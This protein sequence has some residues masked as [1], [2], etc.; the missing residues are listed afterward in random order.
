MWQRFTPDSRAAILR[1]Q[2]IATGLK[3]A[4]IS[5][6]HLFLAVLEA[7]T[8]DSPLGVLLLSAGLKRE[9]TRLYVEASFALS[10]NTGPT[11]EPILT[12]DAKRVLEFAANESVRAGDSLIG[13]DHL[14]LACL[15]P[16]EDSSLNSTLSSLGWD[17][18][19]LRAKRRE[20]KTLPPPRH[21]GNPLELLTGNSQRAIEAAYN[22][23][24]ATWCG[25]ISTAHLLLGV[26]ENE[27][28]IERI[29]H[30]NVA[31]D[32]LKAQTRATIRSDSQLAITEKRFDKG[33]KRALDRTK[34]EAQQRGYSFIGPDHLLLG[35]LPQNATLREK[36]TWGAQ[37]PDEAANVLKSIDATKLR[38][39]A[40]P[41]RQAP[42]PSTKVPSPDKARG[43]A[44]TVFVCMAVV[45][46][47]IA[48]KVALTPFR[49]PPRLQDEIALCFFFL[50]L[51]GSALGACWMQ[52]TSRK[53]HIKFSWIA[54]FTGFLL[55]ASL[56]ILNL[57]W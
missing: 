20:L 31:V 7:A 33:A 9:E 24:R 34:K 16:Q 5:S 18:A 1:A 51:I 44:L 47:V 21:K 19:V 11:S 14:L 50:I 49:N 15:R 12:P 42:L 55:G 4:D 54:A 38:E 35:L 46:A 6:A 26:L 41:L 8:P 53:P 2:N 56:V 45:G 3:S 32:E 25:R 30:L 27:D 40:G 52:I 57:S 37:V 39:L 23:M 43:I 29:N 36:L 22:A 17:L 28:T 10:N 13:L 48:S